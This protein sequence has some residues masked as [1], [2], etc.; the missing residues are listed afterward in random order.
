MYNLSAIISSVIYRL[1]YRFIKQQVNT[2]FICNSLSSMLPIFSS[3][4]FR[5][6]QHNRQ[7]WTILRGRNFLCVV[8]FFS[9][10]LFLTIWQ[11][12]QSE[13]HSLNSSISLTLVL[14]LCLLWCVLLCV[15][16]LYDLFLLWLPRLLLFVSLLWY[17]CLCLSVLLWWLLWQ[18]DVLC[19]LVFV[20]NSYFNCSNKL[21]KVC[22][23]GVSISALLLFDLLWS[24]Y[25]C[26]WFGV[27]LWCMGLYWWR[28]QSLMKWPSFPHL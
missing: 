13:L 22:V 17:L 25:E 5:P 4:M 20:V 10:D 23:M 9:I 26:L 14:W 15:F 1:I 19:E 3:A 8:R 6:S 21:F 12:L 16:S 28:E 24:A 7:I 18:E 2:I 27:G 11:V